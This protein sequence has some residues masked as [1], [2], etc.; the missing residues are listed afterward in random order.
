M[1]GFGDILQKAVYLGVGLASYAGE[2]AGSKLNE[3]RAE[4]EKLAD[5]LVK[6]GEMSTEEARRFVDD[7]VQQAQQQ[8]PP[9]EA[10]GDKKNTEPRRIEIVSEEEDASGKDTKQAGG[11]DKLRE[12]VQTLQDEL[13]R[14]KRD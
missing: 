5:E 11:V 3:L 10:A 12:Q 14:L 6:R 8:P 7:M 1:P 9:V 4:A 2:K 13:R